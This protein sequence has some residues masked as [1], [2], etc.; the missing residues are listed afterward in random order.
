M[1]AGEEPPARDPRR[2]VGQVLAGRYRIDELVGDGGMGAVYRAE[3]QTLHQR[4]TIKVLHAEVKGDAAIA[5]R[6][7][8]EAIAG[9]IVKHPNVATAVESG[10][11]EDGSHFLVLEHIEGEDLRQ[12][13]DRGP[14]APVRALRITRQI[15]L[16]LE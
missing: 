7:A 10:D 4:V 12:V 8:R 9:A 3:H 15:A 14:L 6:F 13:I 2:I 5:A 16:A 1:V 11:L